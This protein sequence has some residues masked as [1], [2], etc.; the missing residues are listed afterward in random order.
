[1]LE[2]VK[3]ADMKAVARRLVK[4]AREGD[5]PAIRELCCERSVP[6]NPQTFAREAATAEGAD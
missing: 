3:E 2:A 5:V 1:M 6:S 4:L